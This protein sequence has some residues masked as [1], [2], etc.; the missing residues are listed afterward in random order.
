MRFFVND[1]EVFNFN[2]DGTTYGPCL[3]GGKIGFRQLAPMIGEY[4][5]LKVYS[6]EN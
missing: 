1:L 3:E 2:D 5:K 4:S 6:F